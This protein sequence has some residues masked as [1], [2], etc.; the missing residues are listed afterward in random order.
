MY[1]SL[2]FSLF[3]NKG[4]KACV[5][6]AAPKTFV[7]NVFC[8][9]SKRGLD[10]CWIQMPALLMRMSRRPKSLSTFLAAAVTDSWEVTSS[11]M[12]EREPLGDMAWRSLIAF[13]P[14]SMDREPMIT[15]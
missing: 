7:M 4:V 13:W 15:W 11:W 3:N 14:F 12:T 8:S 9:V 10:S 6:I 2:A 5:V 1:I